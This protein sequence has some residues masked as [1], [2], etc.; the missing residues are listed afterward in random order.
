MSA[1]MKWLAFSTTI[2]VALSAILV[3]WTGEVTMGLIKAV[4][5]FAILAAAALALNALGGKNKT[6]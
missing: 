2:V 5:S 4:A 3:V 6:E 1:P